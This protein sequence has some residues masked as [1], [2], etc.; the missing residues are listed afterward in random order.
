[1]AFTC[2]AAPAVPGANAGR[3]KQ[4]SASIAVSACHVDVGKLAR[5][6]LGRAR[7]GQRALRDLDRLNPDRLGALGAGGG[8]GAVPESLLTHD[9]PT[10][11][12]RGA[13]L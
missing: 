6:G 10:M 4:V 8:G 5:Q 12:A 13:P 3:D 7:V 11:P 2:V 9:A 1:M